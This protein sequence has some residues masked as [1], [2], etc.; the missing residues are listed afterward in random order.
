MIQ[1]TT[2]AYAYCSLPAC[3][4]ANPTIM[5]DFIIPLLFWQSQEFE[6]G[7][8]PPASFGSPI[9]QLNCPAISN[10]AAAPKK[11]KRLAAF[12]IGKKRRP[13]FSDL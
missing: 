13:D 7:K 11:I 2:P 9:I 6:S 3:F 5:I 8:H 12:L 10:A 4:S 1:M